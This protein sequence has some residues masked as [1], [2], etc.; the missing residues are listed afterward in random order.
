MGSAVPRG[1]LARA[2]RVDEARLLL[3]K[4]FTYA[5]HVGLYAEEISS[6]GE[7]LGK[8]PQALIHLSLIIA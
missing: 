6:T 5:N 3:E 8:F 4:M 1:P 2:G 7:A